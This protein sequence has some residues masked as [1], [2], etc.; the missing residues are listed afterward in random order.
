MRRARV[1]VRRVAPCAVGVRHEVALIHILRPHHLWQ[2]GRE[3]RT[4][5]GAGMRSRSAQGCIS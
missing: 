2:G 1:R 3:G 5:G 4:K